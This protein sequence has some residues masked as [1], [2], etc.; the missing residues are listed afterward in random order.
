M[1]V[2]LTAENKRDKAK[3]DKIDKTVQKFSKQ[4]QK[5][6]D[7]GNRAEMDRV[8]KEKNKFLRSVMQDIMKK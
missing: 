4:Y 8:T 5:A 1:G 6:A 3:L 2:P 7:K